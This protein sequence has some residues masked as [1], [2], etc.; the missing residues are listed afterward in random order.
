[1]RWIRIIFLF[2][3]LPTW[4]Q[5]AVT[6]S[7]VAWMGAAESAN[8]EW[9][10]LHNDGSEV[11]VTGWSISDGMNLN[12]ALVG[13]IPAG[14]YVVLERTSDDSVSGSAFLIYTGALVNTG[15]TLSI[16]RADGSTED[17][18]SGGENWQSIGGDN[19]TKETAQYTSGGWVTAA[20]TPGRAVTTAEV[21][22]AA[23]DDIN[24]E[25]NTAPTPTSASPS[26]RSSSDETVI[27]T[28][29]DVTLQL[30]IKAQ[31]VGYVHQVIKLSVEP[32]GVGDTLIDSLQ[33]E[34][35]FGDGM[36]G[37][38][39]KTV[40][41]YDYPGTY[42]VTVYGGYKRQEQVARHE[43]TILPITISLTVNSVGDIQVNNDSPYEIDLSGY[44][45]QANGEFI[46]PPRTIM[47]PNQTITI[48]RKKIGGTGEQMIALYDTEVALVTSIM[49]RSLASAE[50]REVIDTSPVPKISAA[51]YTNTN[52]QI[53]E[54]TE[55]GDEMDEDVQGDT[56]EKLSASTTLQLASVG[57]APLM[58]NER[59]PFVALAIVLLLATLGVYAAPR[60]KDQ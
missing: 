50:K 12:I 26:K 60:Q 3:M 35:N 9:I 11:D 5:A 8:H 21:E 27:L 28:L 34:W 47:L 56:T 15:A 33:Y 44:K 54:F 53:F 14:A 6:F 59:W 29:P 43:I 48:P 32:S 36:V 2:F 39:Q 40:H 49:P 45:L 52:P 46:F 13:V 22:V 57:A 17:Q 10:E 41:V 51:S 23:A 31:R 16:A 42:I 58:A 24:K 1:M 4:A 30:E 19:V 18:V 7:E 55:S 38:G 37:S 20:A 25:N